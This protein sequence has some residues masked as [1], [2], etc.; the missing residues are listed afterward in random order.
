MRISLFSCLLSNLSTHTAERVLVTV[1]HSQAFPVEPRPR[2]SRATSV[3]TF[4]LGNLSKST[5][6]YS[7]SWDMG[8]NVTAL[9]PLWNF[10]KHLERFARW[11]AWEIAI[12][13]NALRKSWITRLGSLWMFST[14]VVHSN[15]SICCESSELSSSPLSTGISSNVW[16]SPDFWDGVPPGG[17][18]SLVA[19]VG[20]R[21]VK[22]DASCRLSIPQP[23]VSVST[24][25]HDTVHSSAVVRMPITGPIP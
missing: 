15:R 21:G 19:T 11:C 4:L 24:G 6:G 1:T 13:W 2:S 12:S 10:S 18:W 14:S 20:L 9:L 7:V 23:K 16:I 3:L 22:N 17:L 5:I 25:N 8:W